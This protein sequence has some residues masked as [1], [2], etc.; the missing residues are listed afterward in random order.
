MRRE[1]YIRGDYRYTLERYWG[2]ENYIPGDQLITYIGLNPSTADGLTDDPTI[3]RLIGFTKEFGYPGFMIMNLFAIRTSDPKEM[4]KHLHPTGTENDA[5]FGCIESDLIV[6]CWG[7]GGSYLDRGRFV[8]D[9][10]G[11]RIDG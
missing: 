11:R 8:S 4:M 9:L 6:A 3:R 10:I 1:A 7:R 5:W 2:E